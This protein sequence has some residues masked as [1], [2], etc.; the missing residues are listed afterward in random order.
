MAIQFDKPGALDW[1]EERSYWRD[2]MRFQIF[3]KENLRSEDSVKTL[4]KVSLS[5]R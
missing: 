1:F 4:L 5:F 2:P 3:C